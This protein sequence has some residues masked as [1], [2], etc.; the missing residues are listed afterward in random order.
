MIAVQFFQADGLSSLCNHF[1]LVEVFLCRY[2][3]GRRVRSIHMDCLQWSALVSLTCP[4]FPMLRCWSGCARLSGR[5]GG[6]LCSNTLIKS[7]VALLSSAIKQQRSRGRELTWAVWVTDGTEGERKAK[8]ARFVS[9]E[10][11]L[12][13]EPWQTRDLLSQRSQPQEHWIS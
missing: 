8:P 10:Q 3:F 12:W 11:R 9:K 2:F 13:C 6:G 7:P 4:V 1:K 5:A